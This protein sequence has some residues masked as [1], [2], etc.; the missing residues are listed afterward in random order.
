MFRFLRI[1]LLVSLPFILLTSCN[2][3]YIPSMHNLP[4][5]KQKGDVAVHLTPANMQGAY[6]ITNNIG[7]ML[8][9]QIGGTKW[10]ESNT[11]E[12]FYNSKRRFIEGG[13]GYYSF[14]ED[15]KSFD[16]FAGG[17]L[18]SIS[19]NNSF[20]YADPKTFKGMA[21]K[22]FIQPSVGYS[23]E[24]FDLA[25]AV[26]ALNVDFYDVSI[27]NYTK[28]ELIFNKLYQLDSDPF[29]FIEPSFTARAGFKNVK[30]HFQYLYSSKVSGG[31][32]NYMSYYIFLGVSLKF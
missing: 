28:D 12:E 17:G 18:G 13:V 10:E 15:N 7:V 24:N 29:L 30:A 14:T 1:S 20:D 22:F 27:T 6:A 11:G 21:R 8:N 26:K 9:G 25:F 19:F 16:V 31:D 4:M 23:N 5:L 32:I 3:A 2:V